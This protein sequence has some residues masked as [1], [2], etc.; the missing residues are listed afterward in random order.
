MAASRR[1]TERFIEFPLHRTS[2]YFRT[3]R[4]ATRLA[5]AFAASL[6]LHLLPALPGLVSPAAKPPAA[7][8]LPLQAELRP[9]ATP[10]LQLPEPPAPEPPPPAGKPGKAPAP[11]MQAVKR[12]LKQLQASG[13]FYPLAAIAAE[14]QGDVE[15][16]FVL[17]ESGKVVAARVEQSSGYPLLDEAALRAVRSLTSLPA[18]APRQVVLP[19]RFRLH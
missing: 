14:Q 8:P 13:Q 6:A 12:H 3:N 15:V 7:N 17:D 4:G 16:L 9:P 18:D 11:W 5:A 1:L 19:V 2:P 10:P